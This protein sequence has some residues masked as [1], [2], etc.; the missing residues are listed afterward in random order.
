[1]SSARPH[2][3]RRDAPLAPPRATA[4]RPAAARAVV[5][6]PEA[7]LRVRPGARYTCVGDGLCCT[8]AHAL[9][10]LSASEARRLGAI[11][12]SAVARHPTLGLRVLRT[13]E[14]RGCVFLGEAGCSLHTQLGEQAKPSVCRRFPFGLVETPTGQRVTTEHRCPCRTLGPRPPIDHGEAAAALSRGS[15][16]PR[17]DLVAPLTI[18]LRDDLRVPF[19]RYERIEGELL[20]RLATCDDPLESLRALGAAPLPPLDGVR[21]RD[22]GH[23]Y[24]SHVDGTSCG[25]ALAWFGDELLRLEGEAVRALRG[26]PWSPAFDRAEA[27][28]PDAAPAAAVLADWAQD[29]LWGLAWVARGALDRALLDVATRLHVAASIVRR[30]ERA[31][32]RPDRAAAEALLVVELAGELPLWGSVVQAFVVPARHRA[33]D[34]SKKLSS[35]QES[36]LKSP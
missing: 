2:R 16:G 14:G 5:R 17:A 12:A 36:P 25:E 4:A 11:D 19:A 35:Q 18:R 6:P 27:R 20:D 15:G 1:M 23:L 24:R 3:T 21:W 34:K 26:R 10:G 13:V 28:S 32:A 33:P 7:A 8:D 29:A 9:G 31:G 22:V 30:L